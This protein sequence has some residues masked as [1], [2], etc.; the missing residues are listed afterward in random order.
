VLSLER[1]SRA[2]GARQVLKDFDLHI[3]A[4]EIVCLLGPSGCGKTTTLN[5][6][7][8]LIAPDSGRIQHPPGR[9]GYV[10]QEPRLLPWRTAEENLALGLRAARMGASELKRIVA[11]YLE[12]LGLGDAAHLYPHQLSGGM[13]QRVALG[14]AL[15]VDPAYL[16][17]DEPFRS[18]DIALRFQLVGLL[19]AEWRRQPRPVV[20]VTHDTAEAALAGQRILVLGPNPLTVRAELTLQTPPD[21]RHLDDAEV[22]RAEARLYTLLAAGNSS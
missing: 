17:L 11:T 20:F 22:L 4:E 13:R 12:R 14:R 7:A 15:V 10:F 19:L 9:T 5:L 18:L 1:V 3:G 21:Q 16:L 2:Y 8:G 6:L